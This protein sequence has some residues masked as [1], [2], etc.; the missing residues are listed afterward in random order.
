MNIIEALNKYLKI[1]EI[2]RS[3]WIKR[4]I[5]NPES[6]SSH[7]LSS[8]VILLCLLPDK[9]ELNASDELYKDY[10]KDLT[11]FLVMIHD[12]GEIDIGDKIRGTKSAEDK[13]REYQSVHTFLEAAKSGR[14]NVALFDKLDELWKDMESG[15]PQNINAKIAKEIDYIQGVHRYFI[16][17]VDGRVKYT[18][19]SCLEWLNEVSDKKIRTRE[20]KKIRDSLI[21]NNP[22]FTENDFLCKLLRSFKP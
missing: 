9:T 4:G 7:S 17:C 21:F 16:Y 8:A 10:D 3:G 14:D 12:F 1:D 11:V 20:G 19:E 2:K 6:V 22:S 18:K 15:N 13:R 5:D